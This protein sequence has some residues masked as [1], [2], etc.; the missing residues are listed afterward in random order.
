VDCFPWD[1]S[2][3]IKSSEIIDSLTLLPIIDGS[4]SNESYNQTFCR[5]LIAIIDKGANISQCISYALNSKF[6][7]ING[8]PVIYLTNTID[9]CYDSFL[10]LGYEYT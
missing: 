10:P 1:D 9:Y 2:F 5:K 7:M 8:S 6:G 3:K 4:E